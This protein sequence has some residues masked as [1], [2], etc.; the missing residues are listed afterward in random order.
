V[1][2]LNFCYIHLYVKGRVNHVSEDSYK[3]EVLEPFQKLFLNQCCYAISKLVEDLNFF[4]LSSL[5]SDQTQLLVEVPAV[6]YFLIQTDGNG[7]LVW[8]H[9]LLAAGKLLTGN[10]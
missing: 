5:E 9:F 3:C 1:L 8:F 2:F 10:S 4:V 7:V 6:S